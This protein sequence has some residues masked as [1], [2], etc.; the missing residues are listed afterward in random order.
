MVKK[1]WIYFLCMTDS[2]C[3]IPETDTT[4]QINY[5]PNKIKFEKEDIL[6][7]ISNYPLID[8]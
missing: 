7:E 8:K 6:L 3:C 4:L 1:E 2:F 5:T